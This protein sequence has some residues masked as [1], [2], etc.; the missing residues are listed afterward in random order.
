MIYNTQQYNFEQ[1]LNQ[2]VGVNSIN[3][4]LT[5]GLTS[6]LIDFK[7]FQ[8]G[9]SYYYVNCSRMLPI[10]EAVPKSVSIQGTNVSQ[11]S[12]QYLCFIEYG[13]Q[14]SVDV[15]TGARV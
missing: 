10:D 4:N 12:V 5:D 8:Q 13:V 9:Y 2:L 7:S 11:S 6:G 3:A 15:L 1:F 14:V